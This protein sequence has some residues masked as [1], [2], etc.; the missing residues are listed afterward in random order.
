MK[1]YIVTFDYPSENNDNP[2]VLVS[3][4]TLDGEGAPDGII[5][6]VAEYSGVTKNTVPFE[7]FGVM[8]NHSIRRYLFSKMT[9]F[10]I[11]SRDFS[12]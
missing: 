9:N 3:D 1:N 8:H 5:G 12:N 2:T 4:I 7:A 11:L 10:R 6:Y